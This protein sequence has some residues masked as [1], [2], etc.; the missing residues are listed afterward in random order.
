MEYFYLTYP[1]KESQ[2]PYIRAIV[3]FSASTRGTER[4]YFA[5]LPTGEQFRV[6][7][8][9]FSTIYGL[10]EATI[11]RWTCPDSTL[12][13]PKGITKLLSKIRLQY[14]TL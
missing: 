4:K 8:K 7:A 13:L 9:T 10:S 6:C 5:K 3:H 11:K 2:I 12:A 1:T 14:L